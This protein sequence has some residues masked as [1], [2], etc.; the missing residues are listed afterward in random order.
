MKMKVFNQS[1]LSKI[2]ILIDR[3]DGKKKQVMEKT[4]SMASI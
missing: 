4:P 2:L 1:H 3:D